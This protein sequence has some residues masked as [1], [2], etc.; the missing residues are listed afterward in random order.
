MKRAIIACSMLEN[1]IKYAYENTGCTLPIIWIDRGL[2]N[3]PEKLRLKLQET[4]D[5]LQELGQPEE[6]AELLLAFGLCGNAT[7]GLTSTNARLILPKFDDCIHML[8]CDGHRSCR[9]LTQAGTIYLT[10]GWIHDEEGILQQ[11][12]K[13]LE[14]YDEET[15]DAIFEMMYAH[16]DSITLIDTGCTSL[17]A[18]T[19]YA[20]K[21]CELMDFALK[22]TKG[23]TLILEKLLKGE[24]DE[25]FII[26]E[27]KME[28]KDEMFEF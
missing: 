28:L 4:I 8:L 23:H 24:W 13:L 14:D 11:H 2:H 16:Y 7:A 22:T 5:Q 10:D 27:P 25:N 12:N 1:E 15:R 20:K 21:A 19:T 26:L 3:F 18:A 6:P 17:E 9:G